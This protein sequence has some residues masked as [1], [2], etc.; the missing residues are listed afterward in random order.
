MKLVALVVSALVAAVA[1]A[2]PIN[3]S[4]NNIGDIVTV[5]VN[6]NL[7]ITNRIDQNIINIIG[8]WLSQELGVIDIDREGGIRA[9]NIPDRP[10][11]PDFPD[12]P[13]RPNI[14]PEMI[15]RIRDLL[16]QARA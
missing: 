12:F 4:D 10:T 11:L 2:G 5:G 1:F 7:N 14:T 13:N 15:E 8:V 16:E 9:P 3:V 6:A